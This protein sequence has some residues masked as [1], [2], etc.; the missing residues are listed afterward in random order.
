MFDEL[1]QFAGLMRSLPKIKEEAEKF[2]ARLRE[3]HAEGSSGGDMITVRANGQMQLQSIK[4][5]ESAWAMQDR[6]MLEDLI[7]AAVN[8]AI[9]K[10]REQVNREAQNMATSLGV[11]PGMGIV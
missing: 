5:S 3:I 1:R 11:P 9:D 8:Q 4:I 6:E 2:Q 7:R 10:V